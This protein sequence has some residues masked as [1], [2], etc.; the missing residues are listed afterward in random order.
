MNTAS[1]RGMCTRFCAA[2]RSR[3]SASKPSMY[4][5]AMKYW[6]RTV[7]ELEHLHDL[8]VRELRGQLRLVDEHRD[9][10]RVRRQ[11]RQDP[12]D[13][14][15]LLEAVRRGDLRAKHLGHAAHG[16]SFE[17]RV[18]AKGRG[19]L[20]L[21]LRR[22]DLFAR[23]YT[24][25]I[26]AP[27]AGCSVAIAVCPAPCGAAGAR[28]SR[29]RARGSGKRRGARGPGSPRSPPRRPASAFLVRSTAAPA[30]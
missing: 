7:A 24:I 25:L 1:V 20:R 8:R 14:Q 23:D 27:G 26:G 22:H 28:P 5:S 11:V 30:S 29:P 9:E 3:P 4:S 6:P 17:K 12:L 15:D 13:D 21:P 10:V 16:Q 18:A 2:T 19:R